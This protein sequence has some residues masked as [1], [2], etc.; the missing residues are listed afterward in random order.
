[1][2]KPMVRAFGLTKFYGGKRALGP[3]DFAIEQGE[4]IGFLGLNGAGKTTLLRIIAGDLRPSAGSLLVNGSDAVRDPFS[5]RRLVGFLPE[6]PPVYPDMPVREYLRFAGRLR[7]MDNHELERRI[8]E[9]EVLT[10]LGDVAD[11]L[12]RHLSQGYRQRVG[13]A[14]AIIHE[15]PLLIL[16]EPAHDLDPAQIV[17]MR[18]LLRSLKDSH[19]ILISS[20][21]LP[22]ISETCDRLFVIDGGEIVATGSEA[23]LSA[24]L[25]GTQR[26]EVTIRSP[27]GEGDGEEAFAQVVACIR[28]V[29]AV[30]EVELG[31]G[32]E[33]LRITIESDEDRRPE[34]CRA[35]VEAGYE[36]IGLGRSRRKLES[37]FLEL[38]QEGNGAR[39]HSHSAA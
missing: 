22:E 33:G 8:E 9:V 32:E 38:V 34:I 37:V 12:I 14:Q 10:D 2:A 19:T 29:D 16:D 30:R 35:L 21:N 31:R 28:R 39:D 20:H 4:S 26:I 17:E 11:E 5:V 36:V 25:L 24:R 27:A 23:E 3:V 1:M 15:P 6:H 7:G 13:L 18:T